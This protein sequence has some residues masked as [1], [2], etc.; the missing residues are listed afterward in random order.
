MLIDEIEELA[1]K[2]P[3]SLIESTVDALLQMNVTSIGIL[4]SPT[5][6]K[7]KLF[8][9]EL[10]K[11]GFSV[12]VPGRA[13]QVRVENLIR[14]TMAGKTPGVLSL[15]NEI[16]IL[17]ESGAEIVILGCTELSVIAAKKPIKHTIDPLEVI[18]IKLIPGGKV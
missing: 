4:G 7:T 14:Q 12:I 9:K 8:E 2:R 15:K 5:T 10:I 13:Q 3:V 1:K 17:R 6:L 16:T 11:H 18:T